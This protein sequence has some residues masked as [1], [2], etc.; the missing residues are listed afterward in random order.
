MNTSIFLGS[1]N[2]RDFSEGLRVGGLGNMMVQDGVGDREG[3]Y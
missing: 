1:R 2:R 3:K